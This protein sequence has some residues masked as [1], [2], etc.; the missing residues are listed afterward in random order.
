MTPTIKQGS[1]L[2]MHN[3]MVWATSSWSGIAHLS[4]ENCVCVCK[5][6]PGVY[7]L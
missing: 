2:E 7:M 3:E 4:A 1:D 5:R 6:I